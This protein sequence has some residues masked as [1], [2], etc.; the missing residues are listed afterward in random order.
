MTAQ[1]FRGAR[2]RLIQRFPRFSR[3]CGET[4]ETAP[5][6]TADFCPFD[7]NH[8]KT[9]VDVDKRFPLNYDKGEINTCR[10]NLGYMARKFLP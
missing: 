8:L 2:G 3:N 5:F 7:K 10:Y 4:T 6:F 1:P 9:L